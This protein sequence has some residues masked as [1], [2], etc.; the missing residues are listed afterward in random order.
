MWRFC[1][2]L[3]YFFYCP[4]VCLRLWAPRSSVATAVATKGRRKS[5]EI[6]PLM[7]RQARRQQRAAPA[8]EDQQV[9]LMRH[10]HTNWTHTLTIINQLASTLFAH[11]SNTQQ[12]PRYISRLIFSKTTREVESCDASLPPV[13]KKIGPG[14]K[15]EVRPGSDEPSP[16]E[17]LF[18]LGVCCVSTHA[19]CNAWLHGAGESFLASLSFSSPP[20]QGR[21]IPRKKWVEF[22]KKHTPSCS[23]PSDTGAPSHITPKNKPANLDNSQP[24]RA[25]VS[26]RTSPPSVQQC[27]LPPATAF[28]HPQRFTAEPRRKQPSLCSALPHLGAPALAAECTER[29][30]PGGHRRYE[31]NME[32]AAY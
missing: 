2:L 25:P 7:S 19:A 27:P 18:P 29:A 30:P 3:F 1:P 32:V 22:L 14:K 28:P 6:N 31:R 15:V 24:L 17:G 4:S 12:Q 26:V 5:S 20:Q 13:N 21:K 9:C 23:V 10:T 8:S 16:P 11:V